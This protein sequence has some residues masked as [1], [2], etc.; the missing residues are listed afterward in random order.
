MKKIIISTLILLVL[1]VFVFAGS[2][3]HIT[4]DGIAN[5][6]GVKV[7]QQ[8]GSTFYTRLIWGDS[9]VRMLVKTNMSTK[10]YRATGEPTTIY[11]VKDGDYLDITGEL[12]SGTTGLT[13]VASV[14]K[15]SSVQKEQASFPGKVMSIDLSGRS[16]VLDTKSV[17]QVTF[18]STSTTVFQKG[19]RTLD[20]EHLRVGDTIVKAS[21]DYDLSTK[22]MLGTYVRTFVDPNI[23]RPKLYEGKL[24]AIVS[25]TTPAVLKV[26]VSGVDYTI[27]LSSKV[28]ILNKARKSI[29]LERFVVGD[30]IR[31]YGTLREVDDQII[32]AD[33]IRNTN[34]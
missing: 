8:A 22:I 18:Q 21:G 12:E 14:I 2:E 27:N 11:E 13:L 26:V 28:E 7:M 4:K 19:S 32:D 31:L 20:L 29:T 3:V 10:F 9:F 6:I 33:I 16:F 1:P 23:Y 34:L 30:N 5:M 25:T 24:S 17:G 15:N